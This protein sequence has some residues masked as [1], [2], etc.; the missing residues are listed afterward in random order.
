[1]AHLRAHWVGLVTWK[2]AYK[3]S[4]KSPELTGNLRLHG[5]STAKW[6]VHSNAGYLVLEPHTKFCTK[7]I[8][9]KSK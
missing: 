9:S 7:A 6:H 1:M 4:R 2:G 5:K 8:H 3:G